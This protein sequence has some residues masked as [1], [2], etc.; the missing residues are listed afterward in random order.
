MIFNVLTLYPELIDEYAKT[1]VVGRGVKSGILSINSVNI[2]DYTLN[3]HGCVDDYPYGGGAGMI[4]MAQ[5][6]Y[7]CIT[8]VRQNKDIP[9]IFF[10]PKGRPFTTS[11]AKEY[12]KYSET[13]L[14]CGHFEGID[15]RAL[16]LCV[17]DELSMGD[18]ILTG[19]HLA[20][21]C[22]RCV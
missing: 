10:S 12:I 5:P 4:M 15:Q 21:M 6:V 16:D 22:F 11:I 9:V 1:G 13:I 20:A 2:R 14:L 8:A 17:T 19:G 3:K 18:Y 7:D